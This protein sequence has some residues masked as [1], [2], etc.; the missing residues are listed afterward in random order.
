MSDEK[1]I[2]RSLDLNLLV[3]FDAVMVERNISRAADRLGLSQPAASHAL[4][5]LRHMMKDP[6]FVRTPNGMEPTPRAESIAPLIRK[7]LGELQA[8]FEPD[9]FDTG[10]EDRTFRLGLNNYAAIVLAPLAGKAAAET[11]PHV[12][13]VMRPSGTLDIETMLDRGEI[14]LAV[15]NERQHSE[16]LA[17]Q[18]LVEEPFVA[19]MRQ[20]HPAA[21]G[22]SLGAMGEYEFL[23]I[24]SSGDDTGFIDDV[25]QQHGLKRRIAITAPFLSAPGLLHHSD[26]IAIVSHGIAAGFAL[27]PNLVHVPLPFPTPMVR[28][29]MMWHRRYE[30]TGPHR[31][32][33][34]LF[35]GL[36]RTTAKG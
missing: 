27:M 35:A 6:L 7:S 20:G 2:R 34:N 11:A 21:S 28:V 13:F 29:M 1:L 5:R 18:L 3:I 36:G 24:S 14:D 25:M 17:S 10:I 15:V 30:H 8:A 26:L 33:R 9:V 32:L 22:L 12:S 31:W 23:Q 16:R 19:L 4:N